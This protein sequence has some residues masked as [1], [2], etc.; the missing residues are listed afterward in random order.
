[1]RLLYHFCFSR[2][3]R[4]CSRLGSR[5]NAA[6]K[7]VLEGWCQNGVQPVPK[8]N[9]EHKRQAE[10]RPLKADSHKV[11]YAKNRPIRRS[12]VSLLVRSESFALHSSLGSHY[13]ALTAMSP[14]AVITRR[15]PPWLLAAAGLLDNWCHWHYI[16]FPGEWSWSTFWT[17]SKWFP[18]KRL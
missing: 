10:L 14:V 4:G 1:V 12:L 18:T 9:T 2:Q 11:H 7:N 15:L 17:A 5:A 8:S 6:Q 13:E 3:K 16:K